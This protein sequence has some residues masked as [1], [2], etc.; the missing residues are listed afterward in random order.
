MAD[1]W[2]TESPENRDFRFRKGHLYPRFELAPFCNW[3]MEGPELQERHLPEARGP[4]TMHSASQGKW[5]GPFIFQP[6]LNSWGGKR[7][8]A[9]SSSSSIN[10]TRNNVNE[11]L[12][13]ER[14]VAVI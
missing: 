13:L 11:E 10:V 3:C 12:N 7:N 6:H 1:V 9:V 14:D 4:C 5:A 8:S 2:V